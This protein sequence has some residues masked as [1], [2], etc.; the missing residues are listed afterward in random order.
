MSYKI[1]KGD[2]FKCIKD[3]AMEWGLVAY[4]KGKVY[5]S[6]LNRC[7]TDDQLNE[8]HGMEHEVS[9]FEHFVQIEAPLETPLDT[10]VGGSHYKDFK[11]Q[12]I[13]FILANGLSF[14]QGSVLKYIL[15]DK[16]SKVVDLKKAI[17]LLE[18]EIQD[19]EKN[20]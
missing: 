7:I 9:F 5:E 17:H 4:S 8:A 6:E 20:T 14:T 2:R 16:D 18:I 10:Q 13:E 12:P 19:I 1:K 15:R 11:I 3:Y